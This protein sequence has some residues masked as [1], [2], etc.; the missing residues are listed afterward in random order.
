MHQLTRT[1]KVEYYQPKDTFGIDRD[2]EVLIAYHPFHSAERW[3]SQRFSVWN[4]WRAWFATILM[5]LFFLGQGPKAIENLIRTLGFDSNAPTGAAATGLLSGAD[6]VSAVAAGS[7][8]SATTAL[9]VNTI[10]SVM[11]LQIMALLSVAV[12]GIAGYGY[13]KRPTHLALSK[14]GIA[15][16][17]RRFALSSGCLIPWELV[18]AIDLEW[19]TGK[20]SPLD[21][22][23]KIRTTDQRTPMQLKFG[24]LAS[25]EDRQAFLDHLDKWA[26]NVTKDAR[27]V[28]M[29]ATPQDQSYTELWLKALSAP[30]ERERLTPLM[31]NTTLQDGRFE[32]FGQLGVGG[33]GTAYEARQDN[34]EDAVLKEFILPVYVDINVRK[35]ALE[36]MQNEVRMLKALNHE[37]IVKLKD[38]FVEDHRG[39]LVLEK[40]DG[41]SLRMIVDVDGKMDEKRVVQMAHQMCDMLVYLHGL[42]PPI[43]HRD[44]TPDN[45]I[46]R[47]DGMLKL[48]DFNVAQQKEHTVTSTVV[49][50]QAYLPPEQF[51]GKPTPQS[52]IYAMGATLYFLL[53]G[54]DPE[55]ISIAHPQE[56]EASISS[57]LDLLVARATAL[58]TGL[59]HQNIEELKEE[60]T[61]IEPAQSDF[62][63]NT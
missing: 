39:Y 27:L 40:I 16:E 61:L 62:D 41:L 28:E 48:V 56:R 17:W 10:S 47:K 12:A 18:E 59:R 11:V 19:P 15:W 9:S 46:L 32:V 63:A 51:R 29:L 8:T 44:F 7:L 20:A 31:A 36:R 21:C 35:Q 25:N 52:D 1:T 33:Q 42:S 30:P 3:L 60:L 22:I 45:L 26:P 38:F 54:V 50:K 43:V 23:I 55:P 13:L 24:G 34:G 58:D 5:V 14:R 57:E 37:K 6:P 49:G 2:H 4:S 53:T